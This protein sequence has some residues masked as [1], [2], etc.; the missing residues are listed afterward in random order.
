MEVLGGGCG[1][2]ERLDEDEDY[3]APYIFENSVAW[4]RYNRKVGQDYTCRYCFDILLSGP[5]EGLLTKW[6]PTV[7]WII[8]EEGTSNHAE[9]R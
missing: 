7:A 8:I 4:A 6:S 1:K 9:T 5:A 2:N 3:C